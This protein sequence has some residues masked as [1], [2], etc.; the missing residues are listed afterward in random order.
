MENSDFKII[1]ET[2][3]NTS[4][5]F[6][7]AHRVIKVPYEIGAIKRDIML[8]KDSVTVL[9]IDTTHDEPMTP[10][11]REYHSGVNEVTYGFP[12]RL[13]E[14]DESP[15]QAAIRELEEELGVKILSHDIMMKTR[16]NLSEGCSNE[17]SHVMIISG[18]T[19]DKEV[20]FDSDEYVEKLMFPTGLL[21]FNND[22]LDITSAASNIALLALEKLR[23]E[24]EL[25]N[26]E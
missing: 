3:E 6:D 4:P 5:V 10:I 14:D 23:L 13:I 19:E 1:D 21:G 26:R 2:I 16:V 24:E 25:S 12:A 8:H 17:A 18:V 22:N 15:E 20:Q 7:I 11:L 9:F